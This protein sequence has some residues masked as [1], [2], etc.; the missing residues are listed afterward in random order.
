MVNVLLKQI[1]MSSNLINFDAEV[2]NVQEYLVLFLPTSFFQS[3][4][5]GIAISFLTLKFPL[6]ALPYVR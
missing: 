2:I 5:L 6:G 3:S 4:L 1:V